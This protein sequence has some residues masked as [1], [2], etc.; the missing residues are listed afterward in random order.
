MQHRPMCTHADGRC[1][2]AMDTQPNLCSRASA[3][4]TG[5]V[6]GMP[7][8]RRLYVHSLVHEFPFPKKL[9][10][11]WEEVEQKQWTSHKLLLRSKGEKKLCCLGVCGIGS[12]MKEKER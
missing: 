10:T 3:C 12:G 7:N 4:A 2:L 9:Q 8:M 1:A 11:G 6:R 5:S